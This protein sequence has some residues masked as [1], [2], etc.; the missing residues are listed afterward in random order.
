[1]DEGGAKHT[2]RIE[3]ESL[4]GGVGEMVVTEQDV[5]DAHV[6]V[7]DAGSITAA[8][9]RIFPWSGW[10]RSGSTGSP[11]FTEKTLNPFIR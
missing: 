9:L 2:E 8:R 1:M 11:Q 5:R 7:V 4:L 10:I 3:E 6:A